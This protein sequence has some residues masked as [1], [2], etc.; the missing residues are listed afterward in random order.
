MAFK[1]DL[2]RINTLYYNSTAVAELKKGLD[3]LDKMLS[4]GWLNAA[5]SENAE[6]L[7]CRIFVKIKLLK[8]LSG[9]SDGE[10]GELEE[11]ILSEYRNAE[12]KGYKKTCAV[13][14]G[15]KT[16][17][18]FVH[19]VVSFVA[20]ADETLRAGVTGAQCDAVISSLEAMKGDVERAEITSPFGDGVKFTDVKEGL[21][22]RLEGGISAAQRRKSE[23]RAGKVGHFLRKISD[24]Y[25][26]YEYYPL[27][28][29][30]EGGGKYT[31]VVCTPFIEEA[32]LYAARAVAD[33]V[34]V[35]EADATVFEG[36]T[37]DYVADFFNHVTELKAG[38]I[39]T[40]AEKLGEGKK[41]LLYRG[42][43]L[44]G[45]RGVNVFIHDDDGDGR[46][47]EKCVEYSADDGRL[48]PRDVGISYISMPYFK[49][50][51]AEFEA[52]GLI[53]GGA[54]Y[55]GLKEMA[56]MGFIG[57]NRVVADFIAGADWR[58]TGKKLSAA[59]TAAARRYLQTLK[60]S[61]LFIDSGWGD[62][63]SCII[64]KERTHEG[65]DY[66]GVRDID[67]ENVR[68]IVESEHSVFAKCGMI[69]RYCT[70]GGGD[71]T[72]WELVPREEMLSRVTLATRL[73]FRIMRV[74]TSP[75]VEILDALDNP[76]AGGLCCNN[77]KLIQYK[78]DCC[79]NWSWMVDA[80][81]HESFHALQAKLRLGGWSEWYYEQMGITRGRVERWTFT[82][83]I[84]DGNTSSKLYKV[85]I[86]E[87]DA[88]AFEIDCDDGRNYA[89]NT[90]DFN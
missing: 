19:G 17:I 55:D 73:V 18:K 76:T 80:I 75:E 11:Y 15:A 12:K 4:G 49:D 53:A 45:K 7:Y 28:D 52:K 39:L 24:K 34:A 20:D 37:D 46:E 14:D 88:R 62:F 59:N 67:L 41:K 86:V 16:L 43:M 81:V 40:N 74:E 65:F 33:G 60:N 70:L 1:D 87:A 57:L 90:I 56:F 47:Y 78:S 61:Y 69:A 36:Y 63:S 29:Y 85:H 35:Y 26:L 31:C 10:R 25:L 58:K 30:D 82:N 6:A 68:K 48:S 42:A 27:P 3:E 83:N 79:K 51:C 5:N 77:G 50:V 44:A 9:Y 23:E 84:Y 89:W 71:K 13:M 66:D 22:R 72:D 32:R 8:Y 21:I 64:K 54:D 2:E 38:L